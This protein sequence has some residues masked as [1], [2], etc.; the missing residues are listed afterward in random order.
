MAN[1][2][3][4]QRGE[5]LNEEYLPWS[6]YHE[7]SAIAAT[8]LAS[9]KAKSRLLARA[10]G[11]H[12]F[13]PLHSWLWGKMRKTEPNAEWIKESRERFGANLVV[14]LRD[15][16]DQS[17][18][19]HGHYYLDVVIEL[20]RRRRAIVAAGRELQEARSSGLEAMQQTERDIPNGGSK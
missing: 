6:E 4:P 20:E 9:G 13:L 2:C 16:M 8:V 7:Q 5:T 19:W 17:F 18:W 3:N 10:T 14:C 11:F 1:G 15:W 12:F